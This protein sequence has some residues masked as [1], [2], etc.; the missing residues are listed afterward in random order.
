MTTDLYPEIVNHVR[1]N[2]KNHPEGMPH[3]VLVGHLTS[4]DASE[5]KVEHAIENSLQKGDIN[6]PQTY[7]Y[8][9]T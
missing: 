9:V 5:E 1:Q 3:D 7:H 6:E 4:K 8:R 2:A